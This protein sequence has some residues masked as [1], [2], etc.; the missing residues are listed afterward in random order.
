MNTH[1]ASA[2]NMVK[3]PHDNAYDYSFR[4]LI[5]DQPLPLASFKGKVLLVVNTASKCG[6]TPQYASLEKLYQ[7][8]KDRGLVI[9]G[10]PSNDFGGQE[11][12][13]EKEIAHFCQI[14]YGVSFPM[15]SKEI[16]SGK[17]AH[18]FFLWARKKLGFGSAP[19][20]NFHKYLINCRGELITYF[21]STT[22]PDSPRFLKAITRALDDCDGPSQ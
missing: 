6:F 18:P 2:S 14:H 21:Y 16:V 12:G 19:K 1:I 4:T 8:N 13:T 11:P 20:W 22:S 10:V 7:Q 5:G 15:T 3:N 17:N 9:L